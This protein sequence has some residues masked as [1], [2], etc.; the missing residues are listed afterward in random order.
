MVRL[1]KKNYIVLFHWDENLHPL[2]LVKKQNW[3]LQRHIAR[4][5]SSED[6]NFVVPFEGCPSTRYEESRI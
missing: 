1:S 5:Y 2:P 4:E 3:H 6:L